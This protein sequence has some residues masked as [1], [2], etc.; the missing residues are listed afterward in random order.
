VLS[1]VRAAV[2]VTGRLLPDRTPLWQRHPALNPPP[3][4]NRGLPRARRR[5]WDV[6][7]Q[8]AG[9]LTDDPA[10]GAPPSGGSA[11]TSS[12]DRGRTGGRWRPGT[13][14]APRSTRTDRRRPTRRGHGDA[15]CAPGTGTAVVAVPVACTVRSGRPLRGAA[16][17]EP[18]GSPRTRRRP[19]PG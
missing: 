18:R 17:G 10:R 6:A 9:L 19:P 5:S 4:R 12:S 8:S 2:S 3:R 15:T 16:S 11:W 7:V 13:P 14:R 1:A